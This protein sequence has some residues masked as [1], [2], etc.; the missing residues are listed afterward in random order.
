MFH[1]VAS[2]RFEAQRPMPP[3]DEQLALHSAT[4]LGVFKRHEQLPPPPERAEIME[5]LRVFQTED[6][7][8]PCWDNEQPLPVGT[9]AVVFLH[10]DSSRRVFWLGWVE[11]ARVREQRLKLL[12]SAKHCELHGR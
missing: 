9:E 3:G 2:V 5:R 8:Y 10:W 4:V 7:H 12:K 1:A 6:G 11:H